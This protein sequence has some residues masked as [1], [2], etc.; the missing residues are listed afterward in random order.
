MDA[1]Q[2]RL[3]AYERLAQAARASRA[4]SLK[5]KYGP[6][7]APEAPVADEPQLDDE[8][9]AQLAQLMGGDSQGE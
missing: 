8:M 9:I 6:K 4:D 3:K 7:P 2:F 1:D 5:S